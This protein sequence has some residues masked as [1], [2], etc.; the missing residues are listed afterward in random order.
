MIRLI[1]RNVINVWNYLPDDVSFDCFYRFRCSIMRINNICLVTLGIVLGLVD[2]HYLLSILCVLWLI[3]ATISVF[4]VPCCLVLLSF[5]LVLSYMFELNKW[6][7][8]LTRPTIFLIPIPTSTL[9]VSLTFAIG[10]VSTLCGWR[11]NRCLSN[12]S[13]SGLELEPVK[14]KNRCKCFMQ[15]LIGTV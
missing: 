12:R 4:F 9:I 5:Y 2:F 1:Y 14:D 8:D 11:W 7:N 15:P 13:S 10:V 3:R 6:R